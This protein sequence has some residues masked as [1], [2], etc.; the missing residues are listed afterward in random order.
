MLL[1]QI[2]SFAKIL[3]HGKKKNRGKANVCGDAPTH[4]PIRERRNT[5]KSANIREP[6]IAKF[7]YTGKGTSRN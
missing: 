5:R 6:Y 2:V 4:A 1:L 3:K 7:E